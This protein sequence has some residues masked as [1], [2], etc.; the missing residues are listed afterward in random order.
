MERI[1]NTVLTGRT[2]IHMYESFS[3]KLYLDF[4][5]VERYRKAL[6]QLGLS[7]HRLAVETVSWHKPKSIPLS[8][9]KCMTCN[10]LEDEFH[11]VLECASFTEV[12]KKY[13]PGRYYKRPNMFKL[14]ELLCSRDRNVLRNLA[15]FV[16]KSFDTR[17]SLFQK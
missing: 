17:K 2:Y 10:V 8:E 1:P 7:S 14:I 6:T 15:T 12:R 4:V 9:M 11:F 13:I 5:N 16:C 3:Y